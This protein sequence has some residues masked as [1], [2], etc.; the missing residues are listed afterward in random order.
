[1]L[2]KYW[3]ECRTIAISQI[4]NLSNYSR[5]LQHKSVPLVIPATVTLIIVAAVGE[6]GCEIRVEGRERGIVA[7]A[8]IAT[9]C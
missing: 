5:Y 7:A 4:E 1:M 9:A 8:A 3:N 2:T 6:E